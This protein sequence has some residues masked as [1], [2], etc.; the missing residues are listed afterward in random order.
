MQDRRFYAAFAG[1]NGYPDS[2]LSGCIQDVLKMDR[3]FRDQ[4]AAQEGL[5][6]HPAYYLQPN[7][8]DLRL[9]DKYA[10]T[11]DAPLTWLPPTF[12]NFTQ[13]IFTHF[14]GAKAGDICVFFY[15]GHG[16]QTPAPPEFHRNNPSRKLQ[17]FVCADSRT[18]ARDL[19]NKEF[20]YLL[21]K[22][23]GKTEAHC[24]VITDCCHAGGN[25][26]ALAP[27]DAAGEFRPRFQSDGDTE[28]AFTDLLGHDVPGFFKLEDGEMK[29]EIAGYIH[30]AACRADELAQES[31]RGGLFTARLTDTLRANGGATSYRD[32]MWRLQT[33]VNTAAADQH[34]VAFAAKNADLDGR[35]LSG[36]MLTVVPR[37]EVLFDVSLQRWK[38]FAGA[39]EG[40]SPGAVVEVRDGDFRKE[41]ELQEVEALFSLMDIA[42][43]DTATQTA[44]ASLVR[45]AAPR[46]T[47]VSAPDPALETALGKERYPLVDVKFGKDESAGYEVFRPEDG[48][49][50]LLENGDTLPLFRRTASPEMFLRYAQRIG[51]WMASL[52]WKR[53]DPRLAR[54]HFE[55]TWKVVEGRNRQAVTTPATDDL[56]EL[57]YRDGN[58]PAFRLSIAL[59]ADAPVEKCFVRVL[60]LGS[61]FDI[62][63]K[64]IHDG[65]GP[66]TRGGGPIELAYVD[67]GRTVYD[68]P[69]SIDE[70]YRAYNKY[71]I[72]DY[73][74]I[75][76]ST[77]HF[78]VTKFEQDALE[79]DAPGS[80]GLGNSRGSEEDAREGVAWSVFT[81]RIAT[82]FDGLE[83]TMG[84]GEKAKLGP[85]EIH[86]PAGLSGKF[87]LIA[88]GEVAPVE[89]SAWGTGPSGN[90][91]DGGMAVLRVE[92]S[93][94][95]RPEEPLNVLL[96]R[97][98]AEVRQLPPHAIVPFVADADAY[99]PAGFQGSSGF[100]TIT[101]VPATDL[102]FR[103]IFLPEKNS[104]LRIYSRENGLWQQR[105]G[106]D[107]AIPA[108]LLLDGV[109][110]DS[111]CMWQAFSLRPD[112]PAQL[113][114][115]DFSPAVD[116]SVVAESLHAAIAGL[117]AGNVAVITNGIGGQLAQMA[118]ILQTGTLVF[119]GDE[120]E[121]RTSG[122]L[123]RMMAFAVREN[124]VVKTAI[125]A[126]AATLQ[127]HAKHT[128]ATVGNG[129]YPGYLQDEQ[130]ISS[131]L[132]QIIPH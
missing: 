69:V 119:S 63:P 117:G 94:D 129:L 45:A 81:A 72:H 61:K 78:D 76:V 44:R 64:L 50:I 23:F 106:F 35:F 115:F 53:L 30:F 68:I 60:Y 7:A 91:L 66:L 74:K 43:L 22:A 17:T 101:D 83:K 125:P 77:A 3:L 27:A 13:K 10:A 90:A 103:R 16:S 126:L 57:H 51:A 34:P 40:L 75:V 86:T 58:P 67:N 93:G 130:I 132:H 52:D 33:V 109:T 107:P 112:A 37:Y 48:S 120:R 80:R 96:P 18:T 121:G 38:L 39:L 46:L 42:E 123:L 49:Y 8:A 6:Y 105:T 97:P 19:T 82:A 41:V 92:M 70:Q 21:W 128:P 24:L 56:L 2:P 55:L 116:L 1:I 79:L 54:E 9:L 89:S 29:P 84:A 95:L 12:D 28:L 20:A 71:R 4:C 73:L 15:S 124:G 100:V 25:T 111:E 36:A 127:Q 14:A 65:E 114:R 108:A 85:L 59:K 31:W 131:I 26:R 32:L 5:S 11:L 113:L 110:G 87:S 122:D 62:Y 99:R 104:G 88:E 102:R 118:E 47:I 98:L